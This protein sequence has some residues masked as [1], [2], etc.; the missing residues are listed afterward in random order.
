MYR[1]NRS[2]RR[3]GFTL[4][5]LMIVVAILGILGALAFP[6]YIDIRYRAQRTEV[7]SIVDSLYTAEVAYHVATDRYVG[8]PDTTFL[9]RTTPDRQ[10]TPWPTTAYFYL[11]DWRPDGP[12]R[13]IYLIVSPDNNTFTITGQCDVDEDGTLAEFIA[14]QNQTMTRVTPVTYF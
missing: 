5:E 12:V 2:Q 3:R 4:I 11:L 1:T 8:A 7:P 13:G 10:P 6:R 9:P 14:R